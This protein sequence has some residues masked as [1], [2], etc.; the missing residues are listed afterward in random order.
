MNMKTRLSVL[1]MG[2]FVIVGPALGTDAAFHRDTRALE[3][4]KS[5]GE[6][7]ASLDRAVISGSSLSDARLD[8]GLMVANTT[9]MTFHFDRPGALHIK[10]FDGVSSKELFFDQGLITVYDSENQFYAQE[11]IPEEIEVAMAFAL[12]E[13]G[14]DLPLMELVYQD[15]NSR[16][17]SSDATILY[18]TDKARVDGVDCHHIAIRDSD[19]DFQLWV[20]EGDQPLPRRVMITAKWEGG[21]PRFMASMNWD[22]VVAF[23]DEVFKFKAPEGATNIGFTRNVT[24]PGERK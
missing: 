4:L 18:L 2:V 5:M 22:T 21:S 8:A 9:E 20:Q 13:L 12:E 14:I 16:L 3:V 23:G 15:T 7:T 11:N 6:Y 24:R 17:L 10:S 19:I 1:L